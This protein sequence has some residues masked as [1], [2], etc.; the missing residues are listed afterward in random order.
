M[1]VSAHP[2]ASRIGL[3]V[4]KAG[5]NAADAAVAV[6]FALAVCLPVAGNLGGGG[7][8]VSRQADGTA[9]S[10]DFRETAPAAAARDMYLDANGNLVPGAST[11]GVLSAGV[12]GTVAGMVAL[13]AKLGRL[14]WAQVVE[15]AVALARRG[16]ALTPK[17]AAGLN[18]SAAAFRRLNP[19][20]VPYLVRADKKTWQAGDTL[21]M[22]VLAATLARIRDQQRAGFYQGPTAEAIVRTMESRRGLITREDLIGYEPKWR[23]V[24]RGRYRGYD[25]LTMGPPSSGGIA[26]LQLLTLLEKHDL[27]ALGLRTAPSVHRICEAERRVYADRA[28]WLGDPGFTLVPVKGLLDT[29][30]LRQRWATFR[31]D[32]ITP[33]RLVRAGTFAGY[34]SDQTTHYSV[35]DADGNAIACT[36][37]LNGAYG[38]KVVVQ[39]AGF[40][41]NNEMDD[42]SA[43]PGAPNSYGV[44]GGRANQI[45]PGKRMLSSMTPTILAKDGK[46]WAVLGTPGGSTIIT[47]VLQ[48][49]LG[50]VDYDQTMQK[51]V[52]EPRFHHQWLPADEIRVE[53]GALAPYERTKLGRMGWR[54]VEG[55]PIGRVDAIRIRPD[56]KLEGG[57]DPRG[58]DTAVGY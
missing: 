33:S 15:P 23:E 16:V 52:S 6:Q 11:E 28:T 13:H 40:L 17:E 2:L 20:H 46:L 22:P 49:V 57:A 58:D 34:E 8:V 29:A 31:P 45:E 32:T 12:P 25:I 35:I 47:S 50:V 1:V 42:F 44:T 55:G 56:G 4:L 9:T 18:G 19:D 21:R 5:G 51:A 3:D 27:K 24:L 37:T 54:V 43:K 38:S 48:T 36:T 10:L 7:F 53:K 39:D 30:Y 26:L 41:L 14:P